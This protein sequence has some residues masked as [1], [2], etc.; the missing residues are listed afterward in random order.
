MTDLHIRNPFSKETTTAMNTMQ[1][2]LSTNGQDSFAMFLFP[3][4]GIQ[5]LRGEGKVKN[6]PDAKAQS[7]ISF[8]DGRF[9]TLPASGTDQ[10]FNYDKYFLYE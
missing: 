1:V 3:E 7:G 4:G 10:V 5:W 9:L 8:A 6:L 2:I